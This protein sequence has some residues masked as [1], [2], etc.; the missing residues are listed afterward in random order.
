MVVMLV[1]WHGEVERGLHGIRAGKSRQGPSGKPE[2]ETGGYGWVTPRCL[3]YLGRFAPCTKLGT[4]L[5]LFKP[6]AF[7]FL[8]LSTPPTAEKPPGAA[9]DLLFAR[10]LLKLSVTSHT[11]PHTTVHGEVI[12]LCR[13]PRTSRNANL[14]S[15]KWRARTPHVC[16]P[17]PVS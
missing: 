16:L 5:P 12:W 7:F 10:M 2:T 11:A 15:Y 17:R 8:D 1:A 9:R 14:R 6:P 4:S 13:D 3:A